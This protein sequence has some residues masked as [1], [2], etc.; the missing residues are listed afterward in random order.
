MNEPVNNP[1]DTAFEVE[2]LEGLHA[3]GFLHWLLHGGPLAGTAIASAAGA[4]AGGVAIA[5]T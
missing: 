3:P 1:A 4:V 2:E 5:L